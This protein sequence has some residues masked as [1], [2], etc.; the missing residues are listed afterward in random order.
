MSIG[1]SGFETY[2]VEIESPFNFRHTQD[3]IVQN[4][5]TKEREYISGKYLPPFGNPDQTR[6]MRRVYEIHRSH[7]ATKRKFVDSLPSTMLDVVIQGITMRKDAALSCRSMLSKAQSDLSI[8]KQNNAGTSTKVKEIGIVSGYRSA[9][10]QFSNW[11]KFFENKYYP[12]TRKQRSQQAGGEHHDAAADFLASYIGKRLGAPGYSYHNNGLAVDFFTKENGTSLGP[13]TNP[14]N[15][16]R[17]KKSW[18]FGWLM[19]HANSFGFFQNLKINEPW[20]WE[21]KPR[22]PTSKGNSI[23]SSSTRMISRETEYV[24]IERETEYVNIDL[25]I[26]KTAPKTGIYIPP[27]FIRGSHAN[28]ILYLH[29]WKRFG[30]P[31]PSAAIDKYWDARKFPFFAFR[32]GLR[33]SGKNA[34]LIAPTLG[35]KSE[36]GLLLSKGLDWYLEQILAFLRKRGFAKVIGQVVLACHSGGGYPMLRLATGS[37][38][39]RVVE[40]WGFDSLYG[41]YRGWLRWA[42]KNPNKHLFIYYYDSTEK[43]SEQLIRNKIVQKLTNIVVKK[44][45]AKPASVKISGRLVRVGTHFWVPITHWQERLS[46]LKWS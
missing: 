17:W 40:C 44:S 9:N 4:L 21:F 34:I 18:F 42:K 25:K 37:Y 41:D 35:P 1:Q 26:N 6:F 24:N 11:R 13:N 43:Q 19:K 20:H 16:W 39:T 32:E 12:D 5:T 8:E 28:I 27:A 46:E 23:T 10:Q 33:R 7:V 30:L 31:E 45:S 29:G 36:G 22:L 2:F 15:I 14:K 3:E 38:K